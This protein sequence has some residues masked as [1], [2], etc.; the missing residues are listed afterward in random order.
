MIQL[1]VL[2]RILTDKNL[3]L[4]MENNLDITFFTQYSDEYNFIV[5]HF[6]E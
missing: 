4:V 2:N 5:E 1:P 3:S 6:Q